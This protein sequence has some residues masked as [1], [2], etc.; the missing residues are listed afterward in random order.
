MLQ[1]Y[2]SL[3]SRVR[4]CAMEIFWSNSRSQLWNC[5]RVKRIQCQRPRD[6]SRRH[7]CDL[8][9]DLLDAR[10]SCRWNFSLCCRAAHNFSPHHSIRCLPSSSLKIIQALIKIVSNFLF[11]C[12]HT[13]ENSSQNG[14]GRN[15]SFSFALFVVVLLNFHRNLHIFLIKI[16][17]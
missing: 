7:F 15:F 3:I 12:T 16:A 17:N 8:L 2:K 6:W 4:L 11:M 14:F 5:Y 13:R 9:E 1:K 10:D